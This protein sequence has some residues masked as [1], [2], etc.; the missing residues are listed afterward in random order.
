MAGFY[1]V[2]NIFISAEWTATNSDFLRLHNQFLLTVIRMKYA[3]WGKTDVNDEEMASLV[4]IPSNSYHH[5]TA[6][7]VCKMSLEGFGNCLCEVKIL[8]LVLFMIM[9]SYTSES[10]GK[11]FVMQNVYDTYTNTNL[12]ED[13]SKYFHWIF[14]LLLLPKRLY[15]K[16]AV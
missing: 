4:S 7:S 13:I 14:S 9:L 6:W 5:L 11:L 10:G 3:R 16:I 15:K 1:L 2:T 8:L 12:K